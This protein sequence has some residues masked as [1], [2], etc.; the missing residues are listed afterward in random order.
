QLSRALPWV[1]TVH[2]PD[3]ELLPHLSSADVQ[4]IRILQK[5]EGLAERLDSLRRLWK[6][7]TVI[8][9]DIKSDNVLAWRPS[10]ELAWEVRLVDWELVQWG[11]AAW[12]LAG[13]LQDFVALW[14]DS[15][16][17]AVN[18]TIEEGADQARCPLAVAQEAIR[19]LWQGYQAATLP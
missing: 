14:V 3:L 10:D 2:K 17:L 8:H 15:M 12:D 18:L 19:S 6:A 7:E 16:P 13:A 9:G 1:M 5:Q 11:D 4:M